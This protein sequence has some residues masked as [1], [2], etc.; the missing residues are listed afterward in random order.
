M[1]NGSGASGHGARCGARTR[2]GDQCRLPPG[3][4]TSHPG[5]G[6]C[7]YH[8][9]STPNGKAHAARVLAERAETEARGELERLGY[10]GQVDN[11]LRR[12]AELAA[13]ADELRRLLARRCDELAELDGEPGPWFAAYSSALDRTAGLCVALSRLDIDHRVYELELAAVRQ[14]GAEQAWF[15]GQLLD[16]LD[17]SPGQRARVPVV[18]PVVY[19]SDPPSEAEL[20][21][22][23]WVP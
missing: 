21:Q 8:T 23:R 19:R 12:L 14:V 2:R 13:E 6:N 9:G 7:T 15:L 20:A 22:W 11:P 17:L 18:A 10:A 16:R 5:A 4:G 1:E 3:W